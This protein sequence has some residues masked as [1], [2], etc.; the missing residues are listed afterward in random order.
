MLFFPVFAKLQHRPAR[1]TALPYCSFS[2]LTWLPQ[3]SNSQPSNRSF[4]AVVE[5]RSRPGRDISKS[6]APKSLRLNLFAD[7]HPLN[8][9]ASIFY[10]NSGGQGV[11]RSAIPC[12]HFVSISPLVATLMDLLASVANKRLTA[13]AKPFRCNTYKKPGGRGYSSQFGKPRAVTT[14]KLVFLFKLSLFRLLRTL[15]RFFALSCTRAKLN[16]F[17]FNRFRT[18]RQKTQPPGRSGRNCKLAAVNYRRG[19]R[20]GPEPGVHRSPW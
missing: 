3:H 15:L 10:K 19:G 4:V 2:A 6:L 14:T 8:S 16:S 20:W 17:I 12:R 18:L 13:R 9:I 7:P 5:W 11:P 1:Q